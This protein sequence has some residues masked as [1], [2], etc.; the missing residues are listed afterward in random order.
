MVGGMI[1]VNLRPYDCCDR[2][3]FYR[4]WLPGKTLAVYTVGS[5]RMNQ[6]ARN[7][8][9]YAARKGYTVSEVTSDD[10]NAHLDDIYQINTSALV[11]QG[12]PMNPAYMNYPDR[13]NLTNN[14]SHK[15][16]IVSVRNGSGKWVAYSVLHAMHELMNI[17]TIIGHVCHLRDGVMLLMMTG[18]I[19]AAERNG[20]KVI[21]YGTWD[22]GTDGLRYW[23]HSAG[24][25]P[26]EVREIL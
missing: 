11:R 15:Y 22:S 17:S 14:C 10:Y 18:I 21:D 7:R 16:L 5:S 1:Q 4:D 13:K 26:D 23:K 3:R 19:D 9:S 25:V 8:A 2:W 6:T 24:F 20:V 12:N